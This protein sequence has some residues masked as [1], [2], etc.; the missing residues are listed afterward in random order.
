MHQLVAH[1][2][3]YGLPV[4][5]NVFLEQIGAPIPALPTSSSPAPW[6]RGT[7]GPRRPAG[8]ALAGSL[9]ADAA[10]FLSGAGRGTG[11]SRPSAG[12]RFPR[13]PA[14]APPRPCSSGPG[15]V[16]PLRQV[17][18]RLHHGGAAARRHHGQTARLLPGLGRS[19]EP[20]LARLGRPAGLLSTVR[21]SGRSTIWRPW[22]SGRW[23][24][25]RRG[26]PL[27]IVK[28]IERRRA[29]KLLDSSPASRSPS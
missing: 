17:H 3:Q 29:R 9:M 22:A 6:R 5:A 14:C 28:W 20:A 12:S 1:L 21:W 10:W 2:S 26:S 7:D 19:R 23:S 13:T 27:V 4:F 16:A 15:C 25:W 8:R 24:C 11:C 18:P